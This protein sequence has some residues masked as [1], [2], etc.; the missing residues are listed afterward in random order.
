[1]N[2]PFKGTADYYQRFR[3]PYPAEV[4]RHIAAERRLNGRGR[5][6]DCGC[7]TGQVCVPLSGWFEDTIAIDPDAEMLA[8]AAR[9]AR[10]QGIENI[11]FRR[12]RA[13]DL[14]DSLGPVRLATFGASFHWTDRVAVAKRLDS[15]IEPDGAIVVLSPSGIWSGTQAWK[16]TVLETIRAWVGEDRRAGD[17]IYRPGPLHQE[18]LRQTPFCALTEATITQHHVW[19]TDSIIGYLFSTSFA[20][21]AVLGEKLEKFERD[22]RERLA[23]LSPSGRFS[24]EIEHTII[25][26]TRDLG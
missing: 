16:S 26:A 13:E 9:I 2:E 21:R 3:V 18:C 4:F 25:S 22:L 12:L 14:P 8:L 7:G 10:Q 23:S 20:S 15:L 5:L 6:L 24:D 19:S 11:T 17:A 1:M